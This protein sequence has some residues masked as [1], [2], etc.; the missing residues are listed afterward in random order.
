M[1]L[2]CVSWIMDRTVLCTVL[3]SEQ[4]VLNAKNH[5]NHGRCNGFATRK[6]PKH[7]CSHLE[8]RRAHILKYQLVKGIG[9]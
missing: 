1:Q 6:D 3:L 7:Q 2:D 5:K 4:T 9:S 8:Q